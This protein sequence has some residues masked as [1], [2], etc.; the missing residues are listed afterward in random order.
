MKLRVLLTQNLGLKALS[1]IMAVV[2][3]F[4]VDVGKEMEISMAVPVLFKN[5]PAG[6]VIA[7]APPPPINV[8]LKGPKISLLKFREERPA[9]LLDMK[10]AGEGITGFPGLESMIN[11]PEGV[12]VT[13]VTPAAMEVRLEKME[14]LEPGKNKIMKR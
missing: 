7:G 9:L 1:L 5:I 6:L 10:G 8:R 3:W 13:R 14:Q 11:L 2:I 12:R 4:F